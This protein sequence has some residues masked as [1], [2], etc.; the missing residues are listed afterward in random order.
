MNV[1]SVTPVS[2]RRV[3]STKST[4]TKKKSQSGFIRL[5]LLL[6]IS[7]VL[8]WGTAS[9]VASAHV[10]AD[11]PIKEI[12]SAVLGYCLAGQQNQ[13]K[14]G[15][16]VVSASCNGTPGQNWQVDGN[17]IELPDNYCLAVSKDKAIVQK[18]N[19]QLDQQWTRDDVGYESEMN[20][21]C[22][23]VP[24]GNPNGQI[25]TASC[26]NLTSVNESWT[27][28]VWRG[29]PLSQVSSPLCNQA[30]LGNR[31]ACFA[32]RQWIAWRT[33]PNLHETLLTDYTDGNSYE[34][35]CAD[36]VSYVYKEAGAPFSGG[37]RNGWDQYN[38]NDIQYMGFHYHAAGSGYIPK[39]GDVAFFDYAGGHVEIV[40]SGG[41]HPTFIYGDSGTIDPYSGSGDM[42]KNQIV[43]DGSA[44]QVVYYL[45]PIQ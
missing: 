31:V 22:L 38:A 36:F 8:I 16:T 23:S 42:A 5:A 18:C 10:S 2:T 13:A 3:V 6:S 33:E 34:E 30:Q 15:E 21:D 32:E 25:I 11:S 9:I 37:E 40:Y 27:P 12:R 44:G 35:W 39:A 4:K 14:V 28:T 41:A 7:V 24:K 20:N 17:K 43:N 1:R 26:N 29:E 45:S 19:N